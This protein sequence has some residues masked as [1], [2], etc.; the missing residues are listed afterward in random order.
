MERWV[1]RRASFF[2][3]AAGAAG[4]ALSVAASA[5]RGEAGL[6]IAFVQSPKGAPALQ[7]AGIERTVLSALYRE[8]MRVR[9]ADWSDVPG[10]LREVAGGFVWAADPAY[11]AS[12][13]RLVVAGRQAADEAVGIWEVSGA[14]ARRLA[15][16]SMDS[17]QPAWLPDGGVVFASLAAEEYEE[18]G[19]RLSFSLYAAPPGGGEPV[20]L[21]FN[22][23][24]D[25]EPSVLPDGRIV[26]SAWQ[27]VGRHF[28]PRGVFALL[29]INADGT[30]VFP[31]TGNHRG[32]WLKRG[33]QPWGDDGVVFIGA[34]RVEAFGAGALMRTSLNDAFGPYEVLVAESEYAVSGVAPLPDGRLLVS[35]RPAGRA[36]ATFGLYVRE[37]DGTLRVV[38]D[39]P[40]WDEVCPAV[41]A[42]GAR[43][44]LRVSTVVP[45]SPYGELLIL[46]CY[47]T[48]RRD[49]YGLRRGG[50]GLV[51]VI[52]GLPLRREEGEEVAFR[53]VPGA[54]EEPLIRPSGIPGYVPSRI[55]GEVPPARDGS[56]YLR[57]PADRPLRIQL[58][59]TDGFVVM[60]ER[61][62]FWVRPGEHRAC[63]GCHEDREL[64][65][66]NAV[67]E[68][69]RRVPTDLTDAT[70]WRTVTYRE[71]I[72]PILARN[73]AVS[74][75]HV[76]PRPT[77]GM[78]LSS[79]VGDAVHDDG[80]AAWFEP[81]Y[82][83]LLA[84]QEGKP[85][86][87]GGRR[88]HPGDARS[89][90]MLWMLYG[91]I[92]GHQYEAAPFDRPIYRPHPGP[93]LAESDLALIRQW[94]ELGAGY[95]AEAP[96][97]PWPWS[98]PRER[99]EEQRLG[100]Q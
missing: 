83:N 29:L 21:T 97:G 50:V 35:A 23:S 74:G 40:E 4:V 52:E 1:R 55:L 64:S 59:D 60:D 49:Q 39:D 14:Q 94:I 79:E 48:D 84:R 69:V 15:S 45:G 27:H 58:V 2:G 62:W 37:A 57:V 16:G 5:A 24:S 91:R 67:P 31:L 86:G 77:A 32:P 92:L 63:I 75:C 90:P 25:I 93:M 19:G 85:F 44:L 10:T 66:R 38:Y 81:G 36:E 95:S 42:P 7:S 3:W 11:D 30:G 53:A 22:P 82:A 65:P 99:I 89:S 70:R 80:L 9:E 56:V 26:Y 98:G 100:T 96:A 76:P 8:G 28:W 34:E 12:G 54:P 73:C 61:A 51:R 72:R 68:A 78:N 71:D 88:V 20:R 87:I 6:R 43:P 41:G 13:E 33:A 46:N 17:V 47:E 18:H